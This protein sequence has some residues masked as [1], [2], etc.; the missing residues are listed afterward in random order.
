MDEAGVFDIAEG[1]TFLNEYLQRA[2]AGR[3]YGNSVKG[4]KYLIPRSIRFGLWDI[5]NL[6]S[7][8]DIKWTDA[9][10]AARGQISPGVDNSHR[11]LQ[12]EWRLLDITCRRISYRLLG[13]DVEM[14]HFV[15]SA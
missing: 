5:N 7:L 3:N 11:F 6:N 10:V 14:L 12:Q 9:E 1:P 13:E 4:G 8:R 2:L 15:R